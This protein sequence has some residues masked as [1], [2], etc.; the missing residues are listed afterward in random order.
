MSFFDYLWI[1]RLVIEILKIIAKMDE[2]ERLEI[3]NLRSILPDFSSQP[4]KKPA[5]K[6]AS[7]TA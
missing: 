2:P 1:V 3:A 4:V 6:P 7:G 5:R